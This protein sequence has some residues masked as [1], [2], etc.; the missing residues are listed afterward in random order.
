MTCLTGCSTDWG[1]LK[2][3]GRNFPFIPNFF[4]A[5]PLRIY[6]ICS[7]NKVQADIA[8]GVF[9][10]SHSLLQ[11]P[12]TGAVEIKLSLPPYLSLR[13]A[14]EEKAAHHLWSWQHHLT[15]L[16][17]HIWVIPP[18]GYYAFVAKLRRP[19]DASRPAWE[20]NPA[21]STVHAT[22]FGNVQVAPAQ[23]VPLGS[24]TELG[25]STCSWI[26]GEWPCLLRTARDVR[27]MSGLDPGLG[28][29]VPHKK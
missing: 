20:M 18:G 28:C 7:F 19:R 4:E 27:P 15:S 24:G 5:S 23:Q 2:A 6:C 26:G 13:V 9:F 8:L 10:C 1:E 12:E 25:A 21:T 22:A 3:E 17:S 14:E 11:G 29:Y 16:T